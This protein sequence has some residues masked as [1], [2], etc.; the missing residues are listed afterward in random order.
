MNNM[1][2]TSNTTP[3]VREASS[4]YAHEAV[5]VKHIS[6]AVHSRKLG[7]VCSNIDI[8]EPQ[9]NRYFEIDVLIVCTFGLYVVE[10]KHWRGNVEIT[11][12]LRLMDINVGAN[13]TEFS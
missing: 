10:L 1:Q 9:S 12:T 7:Y 6:E 2:D 8:H 3:Y 5:A 13:I 11:I 4:L